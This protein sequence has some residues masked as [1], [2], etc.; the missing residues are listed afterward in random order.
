MDFFK[1]DVN[2]VA[3]TVINQMNIFGCSMEVAWKDYIHDL[4]K[5]SVSFEDVKKVIENRLK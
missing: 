1:F 5:D 2:K 3:D 4:I